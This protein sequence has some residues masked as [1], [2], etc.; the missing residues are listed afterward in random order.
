MMK[1]LLLTV[2]LASCNMA[3]AYAQDRYKEMNDDVS[4]VL[5]DEP[6]GE[7]GLRFA[8]A[9]E[10]HLLETAQGCWFSQD[11]EAFIRLRNGEKLQDYRYLESDFKEVK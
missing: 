9:V 1:A 2:L 3:P 4:M 11:G 10:L 5:T 6:C 8:Y 7:A